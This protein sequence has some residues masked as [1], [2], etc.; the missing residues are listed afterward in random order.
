M[1]YFTSEELDSLAYIEKE[2]NN[3]IIKFYGFP[4]EIASQLF[5]TYAMMKMGFD[6]YSLGEE[7][8]SKLI[9]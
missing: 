3:V 8:P 1:D 9:H 6:F 2:S 7:M 4:N 5:I